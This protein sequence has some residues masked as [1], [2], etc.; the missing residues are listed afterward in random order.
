MSLIQENE[1]DKLKE[2]A[3]KIWASKFKYAAIAAVVMVIIYMIAFGINAPAG[4]GNG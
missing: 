4:F 2:I 1:M 3:N